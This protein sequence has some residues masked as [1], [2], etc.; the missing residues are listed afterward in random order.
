MG[1]DAIFV[2]YL[3]DELAR[4]GH[5][6]HVAYSPSVYSILR[7][8]L[9]GGA[10]ADANMPVQ[11]HEFR[12]LSGRMSLFLNLALGTDLRSKNW[13]KAEIKSLHPDVVHWHN[14]KGFVSRPFTVN[15]SHS[16][17]TAHDYYSICPR[18]NL[19]RP[20]EII[21][22]EPRLCQ[23]CLIRWAKPP[24]LWRVG[25]RAVIDFPRGTKILCPSEYMADRL[26]KEGV[27][28]HSVL[29]GFVPDPGKAASDNADRKETILFVGILEKR[30]GPQTLLR[31]FIDG[32]EHHGF[33]LV[34]VGEGPLKE[35]LKAEVAASGVGDRVTIPGF[36]P[37]KELES[38]LREASLMVVPSEWPENAPSTALEAFSFGVPVL[39]TSLGGLPEMLSPESGSIIVEPGNPRAIGDT[40]AMLWD[41]RKYLHRRGQMARKTYDERFSPQAHIT[42]YMKIIDGK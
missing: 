23:T 17:Y 10:E 15:A 42:A 36:I 9:K 18:S 39:G 30:K 34:M 38:L 16:L 12:P 25:K 14:T 6:V 4:R 24:Q 32:R 26:R 11:R 5:E 7:G 29:R 1:G 22:E 37:R 31:A 8:E 21:C 3:A 41:D 33:K 28:V 13:V 19:L 35:P 20:G 40:L 27:P 2:G